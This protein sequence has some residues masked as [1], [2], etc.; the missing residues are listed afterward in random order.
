MKLSVTPLNVITLVITIWT[1]Y[2]Y[3]N[4]IASYPNI[5]TNGLIAYLLIFVIIAI[6]VID[7][8]FR[9]VFSVLKRI[10]LAEMIFIVII[11][12]FIL[13]LSINEN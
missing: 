13:I 5:N 9:L 12:I 3:L 4:P 7:I 6:I 11:P 2:L 1:G 8:V 10:W